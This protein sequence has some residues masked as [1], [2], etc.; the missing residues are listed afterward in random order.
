MH[1]RAQFCI[2]MIRSVGVESS[3]DFRDFSCASWL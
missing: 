2:W 1:S 3:N